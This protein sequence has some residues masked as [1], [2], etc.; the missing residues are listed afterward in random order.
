MHTKNGDFWALALKSHNIEKPIRNSSNRRKMKHSQN[1]NL[2]SSH[3]KTF[4]AHAGAFMVFIVAKK[5][6]I[7][8]AYVPFKEESTTFFT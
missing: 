6:K 1:L 2:L 4:S 3:Q 5:S 8:H 7:Y